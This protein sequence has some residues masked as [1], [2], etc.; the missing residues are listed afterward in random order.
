ML[1]PGDVRGYVKAAYGG[2]A[3]RSTIGVVVGLKAEYLEKEERAT[4]A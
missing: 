4:M 3:M 2:I 1:P